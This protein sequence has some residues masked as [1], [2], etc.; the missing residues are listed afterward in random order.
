[1]E[2]TTT[3]M[4][5]IERHMKIV[6]WLAEHAGSAHVSQLSEMLEVSPITIRRDVAELARQGM[7]TSTRGGVML[8]RPGTTFEPVYHAKLGEETEAKDRIAKAAVALIHNGETILLDGGTTVGAMARHLLSR[9]LTVATNAL[10]VVNVL[11]KA[12]GIELIMIGG[13]FRDTSQAFLGPIAYSTLRRLHFDWVLLGTESI[14]LERGLEVP[15]GN[16][17]EF[18]RLAVQ[19]G[20]RVIV[21]ATSTKLGQARL[22]RVSDWTAVDYLITSKGFPASTQ[23]VLQEKGVEV[24]VV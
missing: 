24:L 16:D 9:N 19:A 18:K 2:Q 22:Y 14:D 21:L 13:V 12:R 15:D 3:K 8:L 10:N 20:E 1:M 6:D 17:A 23:S 5:K 7:V 11:S 4:L